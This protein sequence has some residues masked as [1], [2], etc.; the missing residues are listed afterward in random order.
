[1]RFAQGDLL[2]A[3]KAAAL[4]TALGAP[5][6]FPRG[7]LRLLAENLLHYVEHTWGWW[8]SVEDPH[9]LESTSL[10][11]RKMLYA[12]DAAMEGTPLPRARAARP[13][14]KGGARGTRRRAADCLQ[15]AWRCPSRGG[16][17]LGGV[18]EHGLGRPA[19]GSCERFG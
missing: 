15:P 16:A 4:A 11:E 13:G 7:E 17:S 8:R 14:V 6:P 18:A 5:D 12:K 10:G 1:M 3:E 9:S 2:A 19:P